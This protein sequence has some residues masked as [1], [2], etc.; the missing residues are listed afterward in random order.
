[1]VIVAGTLEVDPGQREAYLAGLIDRMHTTRG[2]PGCLE[3]TYSADPSSPGRVMLIERWAS[4]KDFDAHIAVALARPA[5]PATAVKPKA[6]SVIIY[7]VSGERPI[8]R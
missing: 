2:E 4:Q 7:D 6:A 1:M 8:G 5:P 3:Y